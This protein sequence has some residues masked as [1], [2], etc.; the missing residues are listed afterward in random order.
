MFGLSRSPKKPGT[1][2]QRWQGTVGDYVQALAWSPE[3]AV[4]AA[5]AVS[6]PITLF[7]GKT[8]D[9]VLSLAGHGFGT[10]ALAWS[11]DGQTLAS[12]GQDGKIKLWTRTSEQPKLELAGGAAWVE[13][14]AWGKEANLLASAAGK[15][16]RLWT[17]DG[18]MVREYPN[19]SSTVADVAWKSRTRVLSVAS[20]GCISFYDPD[21]AEPINQFNWQGSQL[22][23]AWSPDGKH[24][25][26]GDQD[27]TV[28]FWI[29]KTG[30]DL[31]MSGYMNKVRE[32]SWDATGR[33]LATG[34]GITPCVWDCGG[35]G[36]AGT[37]PYQLELHQ[38][39][40]TDLK[41]QHAGPLLASCGKDGLLAVWPGLLG[42]NPQRQVPPLAKNQYDSPFTGLAWS[43]DDALLATG[44][45]SGRV[46]VFEKP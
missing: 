14:L 9:I 21:Q 8:G 40:V 34:G 29:I 43:P 26:T 15:K 31:Q 7:N 10:T 24:L 44:R 20:Y 46:A 3:G 12:A 16:V 33:F 28:H 39:V 2:T 30:T 6:G 27:C 38:D 4:L 5:A 41:F 19:H 1:L 18:Q 32:L 45:E 42:R 37:K 22:V 13:R 35:K 25:A 23:L 11:P 36:P 17:A